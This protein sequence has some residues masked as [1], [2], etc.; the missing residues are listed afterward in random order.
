MVGRL[1]T[2]VGTR[3]RRCPESLAEEFRL[4]AVGSG[5]SER[6]KQCSGMMEVF[7][8]KDNSLSNGEVR[9][10]EGEIR[11]RKTS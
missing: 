11:E 4:S 2:G 7:C 6:F 8:W 10:E 9:L 5:E 1:G 3:F